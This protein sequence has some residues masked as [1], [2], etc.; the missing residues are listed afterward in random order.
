M[1]RNVA[2]DRGS[3][4]PLA[5]VY[6]VVA[7][8]VALVIAA[9]GSLYLERKQ[10]LELADAAAL[11]AAQSYDLDSV[12]L[13]VDGVRVQLDP[14]QVRERAADYVARYGPEDARVTQ[15]H[16]SGDTVA[17]TVTGTWYAP[18]VNDVVPATIEVTVTATAVS[19]LR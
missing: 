1:H 13:D 2:E 17:I 4:T 18:I 11:A 19:E 14:E 10:L 6:V 3:I 16:V 12:H 9:A 5:I 8:L 7:L 15:V